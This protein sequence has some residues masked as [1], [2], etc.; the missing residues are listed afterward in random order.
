MQ[1]HFREPGREDKETIETGSKA[2][3]AGGITT[4]V[5]MPNTHPTVDSQSQ[6]RYIINRSKELDLI[7]VLPSGA[8]TK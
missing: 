2:C 8:I 6:V 5:T 7:H 4:V 1:V 3:L